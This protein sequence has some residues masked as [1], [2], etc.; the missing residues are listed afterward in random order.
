MGQLTCFPESRRP[1]NIYGGVRPDQY[2]AAADKACAAF[3]KHSK[4]EANSGR[5]S[6]LYS[7][8]D[9]PVPYWFTV[10][11]NIFDNHVKCDQSLED[12]LGDGSH[13]CSTIFKDDIFKACK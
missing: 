3:G 10:G 11:V 9:G 4:I 2:E 7:T 5:G 8:K 12:P 13:K 1:G 6:Y